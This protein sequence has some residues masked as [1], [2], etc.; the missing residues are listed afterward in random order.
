MRNRLQVRPLI[1]YFL[2]GHMAP[3]QRNGGL[4]ECPKEIDA[5]IWVVTP[6]M[7]IFEQ[8]TV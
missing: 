4:G 5:L 1:S 2:G 7:Q 8:L 3:I 6:D